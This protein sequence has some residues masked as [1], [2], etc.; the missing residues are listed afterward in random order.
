MNYNHYRLLYNMESRYIYIF[1]TLFD[2][3]YYFF[4]LH[5]KTV[6]IS[7]YLILIVNIFHRIDSVSRHYLFKSIKIIIDFCTMINVHSFTYLKL[8]LILNVSSFIPYQKTLLIS[9]YLNLKTE[10]QHNIYSFWRHS[11]FKSTTTITKYYT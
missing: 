9:I 6:V 2:S 1:Q 3:L 5:K 7:I 11:L 8:N 4:I 10:I